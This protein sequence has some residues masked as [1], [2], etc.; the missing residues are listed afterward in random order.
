[1][2]DETRKIILEV[3]LDIKD[4][5]QKAAN[6]SKDI[7]DLKKN[8]SDL[9]K[10]GQESSIVF[11]ENAAKL[12]E[13][14]GEHR[15]TNKTIDTVTKFNKA[16]E[17]SY[18]Q[19]TRKLQL[20]QVAL[21]NLEGTLKRNKDGTF[22][23]TDAYKKQKEGVDQ[24][25]A[26]I[27]QFDQGINDGRSNVG[28]YASSLKDAIAGSGLFGSQLSGITGSFG[29]LNTGIKSAS[30][31]FTTLKGAI[32]GTGI[33]LLLIAFVSLISFFKST[34]EGAT[35]LEGVMG[36]VGAAIK[37]VSGYFAQ[38]GNAIFSS[39][40]SVNGFKAGLSDLGTFI[41]DNIANRFKA[42]ITF[43]EAVGL[44]LEFKFKEAALKAVDATVQLTTGIT[45]ITK[46][47]IELTDEM[48]AAALAA[49]EYAKS[50]DNVNDKERANSVIIANNEELITKWII[51]SKNKSLTYQEQ[52]ALL[53][54]ASKKETE[55]LDLQIKN[56]TERLKL[57]QGRNEA[58]RK[59]LG[60]KLAINDELAQE[61][62]DQINKLTKLRTE[63]S[64]LQDKI[65]N[66][67]DAILE[68]QQA[69]RDKAYA[70]ELKNL[71]ELE[72]A[73]SEFG[74]LKIQN[75]ANQLNRELELEKNNQAQILAD[76]I[77]SEGQ[78]A[79]LLD[80]SAQNQIALIQQR[81]Q[82]EI[83]IEKTKA[84]FLAS[85]D[86]ISDTERLR[87]NEEFEEKKKSILFASGQEEVKITS[88]TEKLKQA[89]QEKTAKKQ[90][91]AVAGGAKVAA[92]TLGTLAKAFKQ[93]SKEYKA[94]ASAQAVIDTYGAANAA[95]KSAAEVPLIGNILAPIAA[96]A[97]VVA[98]LI[99]VRNINKAAK[100]GIVGGKPHS[101]GGT[102]FFGEDGSIFEAERDELMV[103]VNKYDTPRLSHLSNVN[104][105]HGKSFFQ[106]GGLF[107]PGSFSPGQTYLQ[108][109]GFALRSTTQPVYDQLNIQQ[110]IRDTM[111]S[112]P[113]IVTYIKDVNDAQGRLNEVVSRARI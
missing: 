87:I 84:D 34:D 41:V 15:N 80:Q 85:Q 28:N 55:N 6:I 62:V 92:N 67:S 73:E 68:K 35:K 8:Q 16:A 76:K 54:K 48:K 112:M 10:S 106:D 93:N 57:I 105:I 33:G 39:L 52:L 90:E 97:A 98:G 13:L 72:K 47:T 32:A 24:T 44:M 102:K 14:Q 74:I 99:N 100:G 7:I 3:D 56:E 2:A 96:G 101:Q 26:S 46:K 27:I 40:T 83:L 111:L 9:K 61:E 81:A 82:A 49:Y 11:Q 43:G 4:L 65:S 109:G 75:K 63:S 71:L 51:Q 95:Y 42:L 79:T 104:S 12:R 70:D 89:E 19:L 53:D 31:G 22:E 113:P 1:M 30:S 103:V 25:K 59:A 17:G 78:K 21:K 50:M 20:E 94:I 86:G 77:L 37:V 29:G 88:E 110:I 45:D 60:G 38:L 108:D 66:R 36:G 18:E 64:N 91:Q 23:L 58:E 107:S 5:H 69:E